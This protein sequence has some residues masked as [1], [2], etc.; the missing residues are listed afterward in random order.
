MGVW[1]GEDRRLSKR[2][3]TGKME[4]KPKILGEMEAA[5][6]YFYKID[7]RWIP[8][9]KAE[10]DAKPRKPGLGDR[11]ARTTSPANTR[12]PFI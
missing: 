11:A 12:G 10:P 6:K 2:V 5:L 8:T 4:L 1:Q 3:T 7:P 9:A